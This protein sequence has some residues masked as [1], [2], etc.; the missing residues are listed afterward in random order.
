MIP[1][2]SSSVPNH[3]KQGQSNN[4]CKL[5]S[6]QTDKKKNRKLLRNIIILWRA[7][8]EEVF[9]GCHFNG[10]A[11][12]TPWDCLPH[13]IIW[14]TNYKT[15]AGMEREP[16][17]HKGKERTGRC[18]RPPK[19]SEGWL[20][21]VSSKGDNKALWMIAQAEWPHWKGCDRELEGGMKQGRDSPGE[22]DAHFR[23]VELWRRTQKNRLGRPYHWGGKQFPGC[24]HCFTHQIW[25]FN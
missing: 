18:K 24:Q 2:P 4:S 7:S 17:W 11:H 20:C 8:R 5:I 23:G 21:W 6:Q 14:P 25:Q 22:K 16:E 3:E 15:A 10:P 13:T 1:I 19:K 12:R 9:E